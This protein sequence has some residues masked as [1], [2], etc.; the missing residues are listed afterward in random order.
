MCDSQGKMGKTTH[1]IAA[2]PFTSIKEQL[3]GYVKGKGGGSKQRHKQQPK[4]KWK[5]K[6]KA[7]TDEVT[8]ILKLLNE[9]TQVSENRE[10]LPHPVPPSNTL[11]QAPRW[12]E[13]LPEPLHLLGANPWPPQP[14]CP[15]LCCQHQQ[16]LRP[17]VATS[18]A[19]MPGQD[20]S[21]LLNS[22]CG[23]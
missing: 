6:K 18:L 12:W 2:A 23:V 11:Q 9:L 16:K 21:T 20:A 10:G 22:S 19:I 5:K 4:K 17:L 1:T 15:R 3:K 14:S 8:V 7:Q 13:K